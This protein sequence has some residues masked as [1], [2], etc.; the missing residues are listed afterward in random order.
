M[1]YEVF[2][3]QAMDLLTEYGYDPTTRALRKIWN[4]Y[5]ENKANLIGILSKHPN[6]NPE[7]NYISFS[8]DYNR[9]IDMTQITK[10]VEWCENNF[11]KIAKDKTVS[12]KTYS[13]LDKEIRDLNDV[14][15]YIRNINDKNLCI[16]G[17]DIKITVSGTSL[18]KLQE[19]RKEKVDEFDDIHAKYRL[20][21]NYFIEPDL[22]KN[23]LGFR[24]VLAEMTTLIRSEDTHLADE[25]FAA[26]VNELFPNAKAVAGQKISRIILKIAK[27]I[28]LD[29]IK[30]LR[31]ITRNGEEV[32]KDYGWNQQFALFG[33]SINPLT[34]KRHTVI[35]V[36]P[37]DY[38]TMSFG[39]SWASCHT[40]DKENRRRNG[41]DNYEGCYSSG[42]ESY[43]LDSSTL[44]F[45]TVNAEYDGDCF[46]REDKMNRCTFHINEDGNV[47]VQGRVYPDGRDGGDQGLAAQFRNIMQK[48]L[49]DCL[50][51][52]NNWTVKKG[53]DS[54]RSMVCSHGTHYRD[55]TSYGDCTISLRNG[56][57]EY[58]DVNIG[59]DPICPSCGSE[60]DR[61]D[62]IECTDCYGGEYNYYCSNCGDGINDDDVIFADDDHVFC[63]NE[64][65]RRYGFEWSD[66][67][68]SYVNTNDNDVHYDNQRKE[69]FIEDNDT[70]STEDG[71]WF[72]DYESAM[73]AGYVKTIDG[74]WYSADEVYFDAYTG[75][76]FIPDD[77]TIEVNGE[78]YLSERTAE[79]AGCVFNEET[80]EW[81]VAA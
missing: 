43:M 28:G 51:A 3:S 21:G 79:Q 25:H 78:Y 12:E 57:D 68:D 10:F 16:N 5:S 73:N 72:V 4:T 6:W 15:G 49:S 24:R 58:H 47:I 74:Y 27:E 19:Y 1:E 71:E 37:I 32:Q 70:V 52:T 11:V 2:E 54:I 8:T 30:E 34:I 38:W 35:S 50:D 76:A 36:N 63:C 26:T 60:H 18:E 62:C 67:S 31:T 39:D 44:I 20:F 29:Q 61:E 23:L 64:C 45:Y 65:A 33:D 42:T 56:I 46:E 22:H 59:H 77:D 80:E 7:S 69:Y 9:P 66:W 41:S 13:E 17:N 14:V 81:E 75:E 48:V 55:Y 53:C 40:I